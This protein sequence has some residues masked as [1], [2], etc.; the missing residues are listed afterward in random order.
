[1]EMNQIVSLIST[2]GVCIA[3]FIIYRYLYVKHQKKSITDRQSDI[4]VGDK[5]VLASGFI[6]TIKDLSDSFAKVFVDDE[7]KVV[8]T[9]NRYTI[10]SKM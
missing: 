1:M 9:I 5:V 6:V 10:I 2:L 3:C 7:H 4:K 8:A